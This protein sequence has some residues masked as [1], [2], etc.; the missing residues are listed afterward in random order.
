MI[1]LVGVI[2]LASL[3]PKVLLVIGVKATRTDG[4]EDDGGD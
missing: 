2:E 3:V 4:G 1:F